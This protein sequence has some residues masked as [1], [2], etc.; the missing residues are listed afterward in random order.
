MG[1][2]N[3]VIV[4]DHTMF[5]EGVRKIIEEIEDVKIS[6]EAGDGLELLKLLKNSS[7]DLVILDLSMP[8][9]RGLEA[10]KEIKRICPQTKILVL[11]M[12]KEKV[13][14][15][16]VLKDGA[17]GF[18]S[19]DDVSSEL[20]RAIGTIKQGGKYFSPMLFNIIPSL[21]RENEE[22]EVLTMREKEILKLLTEGKKTREIGEALFI[23]PHTVRRHRENI[24]GKLNT[25]KLADLIKYAIADDYIAKNS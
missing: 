1:T 2:Y 21:F 22:K 7:P 20:I 23:S 11:T 17:D 6:G 10:I 9:M 12:H 8:N 24:M 25:R 19:K 3:V 16:Q 5:R 14:I 18:L 4:D 15:R 13:F